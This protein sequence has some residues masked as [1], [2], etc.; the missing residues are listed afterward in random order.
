MTSVNPAACDCEHG[1]DLHNEYFD[2]GQRIHALE[3]KLDTANLI[4][5]D[6]KEK[7][8]LAA[9][10]WEKAKLRIED[11]VAIIDSHDCE[12]PHDTYFS[13]RPRK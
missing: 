1:H 8:H 6:Y 10:A 7:W 2:R 13:S 5:Q 4:A 3:K 9:D 12:K 11:L